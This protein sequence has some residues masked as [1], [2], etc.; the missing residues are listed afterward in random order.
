MWRVKEPLM[1]RVKILTALFT[2]L[3]FLGVWGAK[4]SA[5][6]DT[7]T[8]A[9]G[10]FGKLAIKASEKIKNVDGYMVS[11]IIVDNIPLSTV[12]FI[13]IIKPNDIQNRLFLAIDPGLPKQDILLATER[14]KNLKQNMSASKIVL[15]K[16][17][18]DREHDD[19]EEN[20]GL[21]R[22][23]TLDNQGRVRV[24]TWVDRQTGFQ[25]KIA[26]FDEN[27]DLISLNFFHD[28]HINTDKL[29]NVDFFG[30]SRSVSLDKFLEHHHIE[31]DNDPDKLESIFESGFRDY[32]HNSSR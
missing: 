30:K 4:T 13:R 21:L 28:L 5:E 27:A 24:S 6:T 7:S 9:A 18:D 20:P 25:M 3:I 23:N 29:R 26:V 32:L 11:I 19:D 12:F 8:S 14:M 16:K 31:S 22:F 10:L 17:S 1:R 15:A 2:L